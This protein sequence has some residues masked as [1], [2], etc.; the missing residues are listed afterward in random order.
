M[1]GMTG[2]DLARRILQIRPQMPIILSTGY[3]SQITEDM[4]K[5]AGIKGFV[6][7]PLVKKEI[8]DLIRQV[9]DRKDS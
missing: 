4:V 9:L 1:P 3:S 6:N 5:A 8:G 2:I 7:K